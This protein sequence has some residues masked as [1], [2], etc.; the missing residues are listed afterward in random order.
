MDGLT[1]VV[2]MLDV[3]VLIIKGGLLAAI[4]GTV[5]LLIRL[6]PRR[7]QRAARDIA[8][9]AL[10]VILLRESYIGMLTVALLKLGIFAVG[11][12]IAFG[13][14]LLVRI[15]KSRLTR[16]GDALSNA[17][18]RVRRIIDGDSL[19]SYFSSYLR[20]TPVLLN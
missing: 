8:S 17:R 14:Q 18:R 4:A 7:I 11:E 16:V 13:K 15:P 5:M 6:L 9:V 19:T 1:F 20:R 10:F 12:Y 2:K 3:F